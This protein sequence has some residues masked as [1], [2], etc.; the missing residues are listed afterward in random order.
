MRIPCVLFRGRVSSNPAVQKLSK[1]FQQ[2]FLKATTMAAHYSSGPRQSPIDIVSSSAVKDADLP[3]KPLTFSDRKSIFSLTNT[4]YF[5]DATTTN[6]YA[7]SGGPL[8]NPYNL[9]GFHFHWENR[10][11]S[12]AGSEHT[13]NGK[14][15]ASEL[16]MVHMN[17]QTY[18]TFE[19]ALNH[20]DGLSVLGV[21]LELTPDECG[22]EGLEALCG[23]IDQIALK[24]SKTELKTPF[25]PYSLLPADTKSYWTYPGSLTTP[26]YAECITWIVFRDP[27]KISKSQLEKFRSLKTV[28]SEEAKGKDP[29]ELPHICHNV[30]ETHPLGDR[31]LKASF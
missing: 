14:A 2:Y 27:I 5:F 13:L 28:T 6:D 17:K 21:F 26:P 16:H 15:F 10:D 29:S 19:E 8:K 23:A 12:T 31:V 1:S 9:L 24:G 3:N 11:D 30:R 18:A 25:S 7:I 4:G 22:H 20:G